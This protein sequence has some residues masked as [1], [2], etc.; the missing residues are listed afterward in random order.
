MSQSLWRKVRHYLK[1]Q[2]KSFDRQQRKNIKLPFSIKLLSFFKKSIKIQYLKAWERQH[3]KAIKKAI[4]VTS[5]NIIR[6]IKK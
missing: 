3:N 5:H 6:S 1:P 2:V 4:K